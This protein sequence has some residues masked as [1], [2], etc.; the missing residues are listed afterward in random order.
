MD[1]KE[2]EGNWQQQKEKLKKKFAELTN[3]NSLFS[4]EKKEEMLYKYQ[5]KLG[6]SR[7]EL[8]KIFEDL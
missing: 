5:A 2:L 4:Q 8:L 3:N 7:E 1:S 6:K